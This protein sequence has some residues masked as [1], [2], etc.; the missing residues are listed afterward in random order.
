SM[1]GRRNLGI[2]T[3]TVLALVL[4]AFAGFPIFWIINTAITPSDVLYGGRQEF[5]PDFTR[6]GR[7][8]SVLTS[9]SPFLQ[10]MGNSAVVALGTTVLSLLLATL[11]AYALS[12]YRFFG[13]GLI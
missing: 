3:R 2:G 12:R 6:V 9:D 8:F 7:V 11:A 1:I 13:K 4:V 10:W 5:I